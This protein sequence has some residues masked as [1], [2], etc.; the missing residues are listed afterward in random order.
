MAS[1][2]ARLKSQACMGDAVVTSSSRA[3]SERRQLGV[4]AQYLFQTRASPLWIFPRLV[5]AKEE[6]RP[7]ETRDWRR[8]RDARSCRCGADCMDCFGRSGVFLRNAPGIFLACGLKI[9]TCQKSDTVPLVS[10]EYLSS[11]A[12]SEIVRIP[13]RS[14]RHSLHHARTH[15][16]YAQNGKS[17]QGN[18]EREINPTLGMKMVMRTEL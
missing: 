11:S 13:R 17:L 2:T 15:D 6:R 3:I 10:Q 14:Q 4:G 18:G 16:G 1:V 5:C 12:L 8:P 7:R 9:A